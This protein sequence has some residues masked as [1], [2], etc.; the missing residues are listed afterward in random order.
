MQL[1]PPKKFT[2]PR[3]TDEELKELEA[4]GRDFMDEF[5]EEDGEVD[6]VGRIMVK[7]AAEIRRARTPWTPGPVD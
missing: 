5:G 4:C 1:E 3:L 2:P 6:T 7:A